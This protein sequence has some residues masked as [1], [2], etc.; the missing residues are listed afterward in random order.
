[1]P[2]SS[3]RQEAEDNVF[4]GIS[5]LYENLESEGKI[6]DQSR[7]KGMAFYQWNGVKDQEVVTA[8]SLHNR[9]YYQ[10]KG[11]DVKVEFGPDFGHYFKQSAADDSLGYLLNELTNVNVQPSD[12][13]WRSKGLVG[14][15]DQDFFAK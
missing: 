3:E 12:P 14:K 1:M 13:D 9:K 10:D 8:M 11:L 4:K 7:L 5:K 2:E 15:F 6:G